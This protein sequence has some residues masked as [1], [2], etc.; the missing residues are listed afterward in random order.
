MFKELNSF[1]SNN[2]LSGHHCHQNNL[3]KTKDLGI[4]RGKYLNGK[5]CRFKKGN[6][7]DLKRK[8]KDSMAATNNRLSDHGW[9]QKQALPT[10]IGGFIRELLQ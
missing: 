7:V 8:I 3:Y 2:R 9:Q 5:L 6:C 1:L 4:I 10:Q